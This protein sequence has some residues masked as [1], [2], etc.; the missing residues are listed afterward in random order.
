MIK[1]ETYIME[2]MFN[3][4]TKGLCVMCNMPRVPGGITCGKS[5]HEEFVKFCEEKFGKVKK[6]VDRTTNVAY[7]VPTRYIIEYGLKLKDLPKY[8]VWNDKD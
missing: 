1:K 4:D 7:K 6:V 8:P 2:P 3:N 5:C